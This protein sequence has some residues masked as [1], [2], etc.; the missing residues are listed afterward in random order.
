MTAIFTVGDIRKAIE[1]RTDDEMV[2]SQIVA[3][4]GTAWMMPCVIVPVFKCPRGLV[5][6]MR[7]PEL[8]TLP[9]A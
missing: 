8:K 9:S 3:T 6:D 5:I 7:H 4:D 1:G 2:H